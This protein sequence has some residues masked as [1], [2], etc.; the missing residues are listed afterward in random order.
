VLV[1]AHAFGGDFSELGAGNEA[2]RL[3]GVFVGVNRV[4]TVRQDQRGDFDSLPCGAVAAGGVADDAF[5]LEGR[6]LDERII[7]LASPSE[8]DRSSARPASRRRSL[9]GIATAG[10]AKSRLAPSLRSRHGLRA[11]R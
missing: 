11:T 9:L 3:R 1:E 6:L 2:R 8:F 7:E 4:E 5:E 10:P